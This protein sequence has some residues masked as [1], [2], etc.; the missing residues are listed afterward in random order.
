MADQNDMHGKTV[1]ITGGTGGIGK[2]TARALASLGAT[3]VVTGRD[4]ARGEAAVDQ[5][6]TTTGNQDIH[7][8]LADLSSQHEI[9]Q[10]AHDV[11]VQFPQLRILVNNVGGLYRER[12]ETVDGIEATF[13][14]THLAPFLLTSLLLPLL[15]SNRRARIVNVSSGIH[16]MARPID[17]DDLQSTRRYL[18]LEVYAQAKLANLLW[19]YELA[20]R[21]RGSGVTVNAADPGSAMTAM[22]STLGPDMAPWYV[23][24]FWPVV[25][26]SLSRQSVE[27]AAI[28][29]IYLASATEI[30]RES[31]NYFDPDGDPI[32]SGRVSY[33]PTAA[34]RLWDVSE[35]LVGLTT[36]G[37]VWQTQGAVAYKP[38]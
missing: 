2:E 8:L 17:F 34:Q 7:L 25:R 15:R 20:R 13:A 24:P 5:L 23:R 18:G 3:V 6:R 33:N 14:V 4:R 29:S 38:A 1:L 37:G 36:P 19:T 11:Q 27:K 31:G 16:R 28:S 26:R 9:R 35:Q 22:N 30:E 21:L 32:H 12:W 10:L